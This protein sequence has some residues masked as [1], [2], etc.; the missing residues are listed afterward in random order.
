MNFSAKRSA[1]KAFQCVKNGIC[2][3]DLNVSIGLRK[4]F[5]SCPSQWVAVPQDIYSF[6]E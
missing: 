4:S 5:W 2:D 1:T 6:V 3:E